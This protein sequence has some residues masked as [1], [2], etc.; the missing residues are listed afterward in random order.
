[1]CHLI[2]M[3]PLL[4]LA[5]F[6]FLPLSTAL[7]VYAV[8]AAISLAVYRLI[9]RSMHRP[10]ETGKEALLRRTARVIEVGERRLL[11]RVGGEIW[12][13]ESPDTLQE[14]ETVQVVGV[15]GLMLKVQR[16]PDHIGAAGCIG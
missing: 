13:A 6:W 2:L 15:E 5:V 16:R 7:A 3:M 9:L 4:G 11:V 10:I 1:M 12:T 8:I 14:G